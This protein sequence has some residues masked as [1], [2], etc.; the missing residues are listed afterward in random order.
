MANASSYNF[1]L[2]DS[3]I[4]RNVSFNPEIYTDEYVKDLQG[5]IKSNETDDSRD[6]LARSVLRDFYD[7]YYSLDRLS[8]EIE[9]QT[10]ATEAQ[11]TFLNDFETELISLIDLRIDNVNIADHNRLKTDRSFFANFL[12]REVYQS[13]SNTIDNLVKL[14]SINLDAQS[15]LSAQ[16]S[17]ITA[18]DLPAESRLDV[19]CASPF[20]YKFLKDEYSW[21][22][23]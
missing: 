17:T 14:S 9:Q 22:V 12:V 8:R 15:L 23:N 5:K 18:A 11:K 20:L 10:N 2:A 3:S 21:F 7:E 1:V 16:F 6:G 13:E 4:L 19:D